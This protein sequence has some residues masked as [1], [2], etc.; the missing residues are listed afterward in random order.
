LKCGSRVRPALSS[1]RKIPRQFV[2]VNKELIGT[3][4]L[5][6]CDKENSIPVVGKAR[7]DEVTRKPSPQIPIRFEAVGNCLKSGSFVRREETRHVLHDDP[8][9]MNL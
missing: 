4:G 7:I 1:L 3:I 6:T 5:V 8:S 9:R 2:A